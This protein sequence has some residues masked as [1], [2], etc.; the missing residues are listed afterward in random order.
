MSIWNPR[1]KNPSPGGSDWHKKKVLPKLMKLR[2]FKVRY[3]AVADA[4][5]GIAGGF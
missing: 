4:I 2:G 1:T 5:A 3:Y